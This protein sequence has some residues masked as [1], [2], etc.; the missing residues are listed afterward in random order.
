MQTQFGFT[1][2]HVRW[3]C[4]LES[5]LSHQNR[6]VG[7]L[8]CPGR[9]PTQPSMLWVPEGVCK[10]CFSPKAWSHAIFVLILLLYQRF[11]LLRK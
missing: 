9:W 7:V 5:D 8:A 10:K 3:D 4:E 6:V 11:V 2:L 1:F